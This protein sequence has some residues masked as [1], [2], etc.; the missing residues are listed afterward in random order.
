M[1]ETENWKAGHDCVNYNPSMNAT[2]ARELASV[3]G[4]PGLQ[5]NCFKRR[6]GNAVN[7]IEGEE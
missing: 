5:T 3:Q 1:T 2:E 4:Q 6:T 7:I